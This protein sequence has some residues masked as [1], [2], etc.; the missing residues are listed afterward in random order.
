[1]TPI[2]V[3]N[4]PGTIAFAQAVLKDAGV[5]HFVMDQN[6]SILEPGILIPKRLMVLEDDAG[7]ARAALED[8]GL[9]AEL[10]R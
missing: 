2:I 3:T 6:M 10:E 1:M 5:E 7:D 8:A 4:D 9:G